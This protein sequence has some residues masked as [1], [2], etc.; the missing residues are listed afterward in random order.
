[1]RVFNL[2][3]VETDVLKQRG[4][5]AQGIA[6]SGRIVNPGEFI[7]VEDTSKSRSDLEYLL[8]VGAVSIDELPPPYVL[9]RQQAQAASGNLAARVGQHVS[10]AETK[11]AGEPAPGPGAEGAT[12][13]LTKD[14][15]STHAPD[16][17]PPPPAPEDPPPMQPPPGQQ[18]KKPQG[19]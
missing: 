7:E 14:D 15:P 17:L 8:K 1:M 4:L 16:P 10:M 18:K 2:T 12:V 9:K 11:I 3:D 6:T 13:E 19:R 5:L